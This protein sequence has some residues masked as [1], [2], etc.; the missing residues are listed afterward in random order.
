[1]TADDPV[2]LS[3]FCPTRPGDEPPALFATYKNT[4]V[5]V[6]ALATQSGIVLWAAARQGQGV[7]IN[8]V[9]WPLPIIDSDA[10]LVMARYDP[11][12]YE[13]FVLWRKGGTYL[14]I[15]PPSGEADQP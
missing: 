13:V 12:T 2:F 9:G 15:N 5:V 7:H 6:V 8:A 14:N 10:D 11:A 4:S 3:L 1:L